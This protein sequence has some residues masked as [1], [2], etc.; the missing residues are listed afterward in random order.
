[1]TMTNVEKSIKRHRSRVLLDL[2]EHLSNSAFEENLPQS[3]GLL[4][5]KARAY[6][7]RIN[8]RQLNGRDNKKGELL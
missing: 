7:R 4:E 2:R 6:L 3:V 1:M 8:R 5:R